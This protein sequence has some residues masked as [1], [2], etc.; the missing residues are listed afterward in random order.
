MHRNSIR[1]DFCL[2]TS[3]VKFFIRVKF[4]KFC[5]KKVNSFFKPSLQGD[6]CTSAKKEVRINRARVYSD[7]FINENLTALKY[8][9]FKKLKSEKKQ[10]SEN[11]L[12][13]VEVVYTYQGKIFVKIERA[14]GNEGTTHIT[15][16]SCLHK[17]LHLLYS[18][19]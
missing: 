2:T 7:L 3:S 13:N 11:N 4:S 12:A 16:N 6:V 1:G 10:R 8:S 5:E 15:I 9:L 18:V 14:R 19:A 17:F